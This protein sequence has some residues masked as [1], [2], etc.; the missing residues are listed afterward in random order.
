MSSAIRR[1][2]WPD[3]MPCEWALTWLSWLSPKVPWR[4]SFA[5]QESR[6]YNPL[7]KRLSCCCDSRSY[8][9]RRIVATTRPYGC[10]EYSPWSAWVFTHLQFHTW[11][12]VLC[13]IYSTDKKTVLSQGG[14]RD[15]RYYRFSAQK[16]TPHAEF[17]DVSIGPDRPCRGQPGHKLL[18]HSNVS[19]HH[20]QTDRQTDGRTT[21]YGIT[22][23]W[24]ASCG[25]NHVIRVRYFMP[26]Y[27][28]IPRL[29]VSFRRLVN[30]LN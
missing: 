24:K 21:Y 2:T 29:S 20:R 14:L 25:K 13:V 9:V 15:A 17:W 27:Y 22:A 1:A 12:H 10:L 6:G 26:L 28:C 4:H 8:C 30:L 11:L 16:L 7:L 3:L 5:N 19:E 23:L 18:K